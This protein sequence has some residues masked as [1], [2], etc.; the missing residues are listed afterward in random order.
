[1]RD[2]AASLSLFPIEFE[3]GGDSFVV[4][5]HP[6]GRWLEIIL[7]N[8]LSLIVAG[9]PEGLVDADEAAAIDVMLVDGTVDI[10]EFRAVLYDVLT[11][12]SG[13]D[14][15]EAVGLISAISTEGNWSRIMG[16][17]VR[18]GIDVEDAPLAGWLDA[19]ISVCVEHMDEKQLGKFM[20]ILQTPPVEV[21]IDEDREAASF[22]AM[23]GPT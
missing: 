7:A 1:M 13:R 8:D 23:L 2:P 18:S 16:T 12:V 3:M 5:A 11:A 14:W 4:P 17:L 22:L 6:A 9:E 21:G 15:W 10:A 20:G 19:A